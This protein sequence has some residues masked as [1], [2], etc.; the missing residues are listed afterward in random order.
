MIYYVVK[1]LYHSQHKISNI[2]APCITL[3]APHAILKKFS[4][5]SGVNRLNTINAFGNNNESGIWSRQV[6]VWRG[7][8]SIFL[9]VD[10]LGPNIY[11]GID[12]IPVCT[13]SDMYNL[14]CSSFYHKSEF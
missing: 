12:R 10:N 4:T 13:G 14:H 8:I 6:P 11:Y 1:I 7:L 3:S 9:S 5:D 2:A